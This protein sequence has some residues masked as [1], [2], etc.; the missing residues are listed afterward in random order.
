VLVPGVVPDWEQPWFYD[1]NSPNGGP[2]PGSGIPWQAWCAPT[3]AANLCGHWDDTYGL[4]VADFTPWPTAPPWPSFDW[5]DFEAD[6]NRP[7]PAP[8]PPAG[9]T[10]LG[11]HMDTNW[12]GTTTWGNPPHVGTFLKDIHAGLGSH[13][14]FVDPASGW[15]TGTQG[16]VYAAGLDS[17]GNPAVTH[18]G[19][20]PAFA[21]I[22]GEINAGRTMIVSW[23]HWSISPT[24][25]PPV[26]DVEFWEFEY[27]DPNDLDPWDLG[28]EYNFDYGE[29]GLGHAVTAVGYLLASDPKNPWPGTDWV[30]VHDN[31]WQTPVNVA[32]PFDFIW[33]VANTNAVPCPGDIDGDVDTDQSDLGLLLAAWCSHEGD[34]NW[35]A[36]AD[37]DGD[38]HVGH[39]DLGILLANWGCGTEP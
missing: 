7:A 21:E 10:D 8:L 13:L 33:W 27:P 39:G 34:P 17:S 31:V 38:W 28:E 15:T 18:P 35:N 29:E 5:Q 26:D 16:C 6:L 1:P 24:G 2:G 30:I 20:G 14:T 9:P 23:L 32:V 36:N 11:W 22:V 19:P 25:L 3:S 12:L 37:L 4:P